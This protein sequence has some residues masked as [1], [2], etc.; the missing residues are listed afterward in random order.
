MSLNPRFGHEGDGA[1]V[2]TAH[3]GANNSQSPF[4][5]R[6]SSLEELPAPL[7]HSLVFDD[8]PAL[9]GMHGHVGQEGSQ[10]LD[11]DGQPLLWIETR[12]VTEGWQ[13]RLLLV[14]EGHPV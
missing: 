10:L 6:N 5:V 11:P 2:Y 14:E 7:H 4:S 9:A 13:S 8:H 12:L 3:G 1:I